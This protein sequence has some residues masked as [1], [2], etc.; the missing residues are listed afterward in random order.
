MGVVLVST[1]TVS[2]NW[3]VSGVIQRLYGRLY[4]TL[5]LS[6]V[7]YDCRLPIKTIPKLNPMGDQ[8]SI[9]LLLNLCSES[10]GTRNFDILVEDFNTGGSSS[11]TVRMEYLIAF[12][13]WYYK[14]CV[15]NRWDDGR[16]HSFV[17]FCWYSLVVL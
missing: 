1:C 14:D 10:V 15:E 2:G 17:N 8:F 4:K 6:P 7:C 13:F 3:N 9:F 12:Q 5:K 11:L 16:K